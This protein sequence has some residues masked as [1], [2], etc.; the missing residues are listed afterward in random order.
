MENSSSKEKCQDNLSKDKVGYAPSDKEKRYDELI[1][2]VKLTPTPEEMEEVKTRVNAF[3]RSLSKLLRQALDV[4]LTL[5]EDILRK[6]VHKAPINNPEIDYNLKKLAEIRTIL[7]EEWKQ[8][9]NQ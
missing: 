6:V 5:L 4:R 2:Q 7:D 8:D 9:K 3:D 1:R